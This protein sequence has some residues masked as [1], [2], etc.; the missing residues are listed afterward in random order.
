MDETREQQHAV[1]FLKKKSAHNTQ[2]VQYMLTHTL[3]H[4]GHPLNCIKSV[5]PIS[6]HMKTEKT[7]EPLTAS[8]GSNESA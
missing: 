8:Q 2:K 1:A 7:A 6:H 4:T 3:I 5:Q